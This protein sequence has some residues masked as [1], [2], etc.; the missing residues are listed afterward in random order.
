MAPRNNGHDEDQD[1]VFDGEIIGHGMPPV[2]IPYPRA[3][4]LPKPPRTERR[5]RG[6]LELLG[7]K[8]NSL[9]SD[10]EERMFKQYLVGREL[11]FRREAAT[12]LDMKNLLT[13]GD[14][15]QQGQ[16]FVARLPYNS[17]TQQLCAEIVGEMG[18]RHRLGVAKD[19][20]LF[21]SISTNITMDGR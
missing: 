14:A 12:A 20:E 21:D 15:A 16:H 13:V 9:E 1:H 10:H 6:M 11:A 8:Q 3:T 19:A 17:F 5:K 18:A 7:I 4:P 2:H